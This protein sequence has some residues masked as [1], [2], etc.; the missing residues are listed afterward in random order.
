VS[1]IDPCTRRALSGRGKIPR[2]ERKC[3][4]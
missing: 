2:H 4:R 3:Y 1:S